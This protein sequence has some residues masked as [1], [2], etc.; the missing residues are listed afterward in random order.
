M[1]IRNFFLSK[2]RESHFRGE[3]PKPACQYLNEFVEN[4]R[5]AAPNLGKPCHLGNHTEQKLR[6]SLQKGIAK[7][8][9]IF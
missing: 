7:G 8:R 9:E 2:I 5:A 3:N 4:E 6:K 1:V